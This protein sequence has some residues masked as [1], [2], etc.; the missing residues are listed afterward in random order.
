[1]PV[2]VNMILFRRNKLTVQS[3]IFYN[4]LVLTNIHLLYETFQFPI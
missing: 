2:L 3:M 1:M 4:Q